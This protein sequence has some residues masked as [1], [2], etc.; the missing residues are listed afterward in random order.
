MNL[1]TLSVYCVLL[2]FGN[3]LTMMTGGKKQQDLSILK[4]RVLNDGTSL[5]DLLNEAVKKYNMETNSF[6]LHIIEDMEHM[7]ITSQVV[8]GIVYT[9]E[10]DMAPTTC[11]QRNIGD[12][13][14]ETLKGCTISKENGPTK[15]VIINIWIRSWMDD[16]D[17]K[18]EITFSPTRVE[19]SPAK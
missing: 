1:S 13:L 12:N 3:S 9:F 5:G 2:C 6:Y 14:L 17:K 11:T 8:Q 10:V 16:D 18:V 4:E 15:H 19:S 7:K